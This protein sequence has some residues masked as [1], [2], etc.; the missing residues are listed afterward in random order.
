MWCCYR[1]VPLSTVTPYEPLRSTWV[2]RTRLTSTMPSAN[3]HDPTSIVCSA[4]HIRPRI[5]PGPGQ[6]AMGWA[7][8]ELLGARRRG[9]GADPAEAAVAIN[10]DGPAELAPPPAHRRARSSVRRHRCE[11]GGGVR[12]RGRWQYWRG[13]GGCTRQGELCSM[14]PRGWAL[15]DGATWMG[16]ARWSHVPS[17]VHSPCP[18]PLPSP[19]PFARC[20]MERGTPGDAADA[21]RG[22]EEPCAPP[23]TAA[24]VTS[25][26]RL[27]R[28]ARHRSGE[29]DDS[30]RRRLRVRRGKD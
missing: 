5:P 26:A 14:E 17:S 15:L 19:P 9:G 18:L 29:V 4:L 10:G 30:E 16:F 7:T 3:P 23:H 28:R 13:R 25:P 2:T 27:T 11:G 12:R 1:K 22:A 8:A 6:R 24:R 21:A 20:S